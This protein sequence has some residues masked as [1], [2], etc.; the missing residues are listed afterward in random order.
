MYTI[1]MTESVQKQDAQ[2]T[3]QM[4]EAAD[5]GSDTVAPK[6]KERKRPRRE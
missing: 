1:A 3:R 2:R 6:L 5:P 4:V